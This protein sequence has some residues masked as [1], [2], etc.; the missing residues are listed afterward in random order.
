MEMVVKE[1]ECDVSPVLV[2][3]SSGVR[4]DEITTYDSYGNIIKYDNDN[5]A[6]I[7]CDD[8]DG[9]GGEGGG[10]DRMYTSQVI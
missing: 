10:G 2:H 7:E 8:D 5:N 6:E 3:C 4:D 9:G 1:C